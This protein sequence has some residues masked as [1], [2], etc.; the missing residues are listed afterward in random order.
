MNAGKGG[1]SG[2]TE[3]EIHDSMSM[4]QLSIYA[5]CTSSADRSGESCGCRD[6]P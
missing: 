5:D 3:E 1:E 4:T 6:L 2:A